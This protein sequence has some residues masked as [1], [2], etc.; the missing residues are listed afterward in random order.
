M[1]LRFVL[2][3]LRQR[4]TNW[5]PVRAALKLE[6]TFWFLHLLLLPGLARHFDFPALPVLNV[7]S[8]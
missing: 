1:W 7:Q 8:G 3:G 6:N 4:K 5:N 2:C